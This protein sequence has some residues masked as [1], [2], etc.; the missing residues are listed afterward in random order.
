MK[1]LSY[2]F[3]E[4]FIA[5]FP[6]GCCFDLRNYRFV[7]CVFQDKNRAAQNGSFIREA[8]GNFSCEDGMKM[9]SSFCFDTIIL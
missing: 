3:I 1:T 8:A 5:V 6:L 9:T 7:K 4:I 2:F